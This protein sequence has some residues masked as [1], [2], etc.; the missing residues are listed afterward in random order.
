MLFNIAIGAYMSYQW[1]H[2][3]RTWDEMLYYQFEC[4]GY[5]FFVLDTRTQRFKDDQDGLARQS[6]SRPAE[7]RSERTRA[8]SSA[9]GTG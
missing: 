5:P 9:C 3:P 8:S 1:S 4:G 7:H 6:P 2:G